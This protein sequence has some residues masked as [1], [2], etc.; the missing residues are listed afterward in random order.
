MLFIFSGLPGCGKSTIAKILS[1][2]IKAVYLRVDT[3]EQVIRSG[4][5]YT[6]EIGP[7]GYFVLYGLARENLKLGSTV[8][9]DSVNDIHLVRNTFRNIALSVNVPFLEIEIICSDQKQHRA[10][11]ENRLSDSVGFI[12][13]SWEAVINRHYEPWEREHLQLDT[14]TLSATQCVNKILTMNT[15]DSY[16]PV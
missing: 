14:A 11:V 8:V 1:K 5:N 7:E 13:P 10:R 3:I 4:S 6:Q 12:V 9:T 16:A 2:R 15:Q